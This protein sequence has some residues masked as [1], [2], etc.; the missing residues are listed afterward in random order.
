VYILAIADL[1]GVL[2]VYEW[3]VESA[4]KY[5]PAAVVLAGDL[6][7]GGWEQEQRA[8]AQNIIIPLLQRLPAPVFYI[9]GN[10][11]T[12]ALD[13]EDEQIHP[14]HG[15]RLACGQFHLVGYQFTPPFAGSVFVKPEHEI[16]SDLQSLEPLLDPNTVLVTH[17]PAH[18]ARDETFDGE[19]VG[20]PSLA[21]LMEQR[22]V[23][24]HIHGHIHQRFGRDGI[25]F[26]VASGG[27]RR[28]FLIDLPSL[29][30]TMLE[31]A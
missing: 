15:R 3:L 12:V 5:R 21:R 27:L 29:G 19:H 6:L 25:H 17:A 16:E 13:Y 28:A 20:S 2:D 4:G 26:N 9:M 22:R 10:D 14:L 1:H 23:L 11:D 30:H 31:E 24:A 18:G 7:S 8:Q